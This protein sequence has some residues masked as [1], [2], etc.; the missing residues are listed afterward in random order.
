MFYSNSKPDW[1]ENSELQ[2]NA[3]NHVKSQLKMAVKFPSP[4]LLPQI[5]KL[6]RSWSNHGAVSTPL[7]RQSKD[8]KTKGPRITMCSAIMQCLML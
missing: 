4:V 3:S 6:L 1:F 7:L 5:Q 2:T 8:N